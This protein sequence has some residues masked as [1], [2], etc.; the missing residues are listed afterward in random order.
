M[1]ENKCP[2]CQTELTDKTNFCPICGEPITTMAKTLQVQKEKSAQIKLL[3][4]LI[5]NTKDE[6]TL[7]MYEYLIK[8]LNS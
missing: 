5:D 3:S 7:Q 4:V 1:K 2:F 6:K 8:K